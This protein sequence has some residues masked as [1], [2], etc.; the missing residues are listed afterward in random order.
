[1]VQAANLKPHL[2]E[3]KIQFV[4][5]N[6]DELVRVKLKA[7]YSGLGRLWLP[8]TVLDSDF[9]VSIAQDKDTS[10]GGGHPEPEEHVRH[11]A[12]NE[13]R[14]AKESAALARN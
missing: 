7:N 10:L 5:L 4:D 8:R 11:R 6:R 9:V 3:R 1:M 12:R 14:M 13:V 2:T